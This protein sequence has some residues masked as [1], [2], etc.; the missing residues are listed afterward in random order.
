M[1]LISSK[2]AAAVLGISPGTLEN[3][4]TRGYGPPYV[5]YSNLVKYELGAIYEWIEN[6]RKTGKN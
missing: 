5:K 6:R 1:K 4:R 2:E 3:W